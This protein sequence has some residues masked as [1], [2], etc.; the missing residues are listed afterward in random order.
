MYSRNLYGRSYGDERPFVIPSN[1]RGTALDTSV[2]GREPEQKDP[3]KKAR[4]D[5]RREEPG[6]A[7]APERAA[8]TVPEYGGEDRS[9]SHAAEHEGADSRAAQLQTAAAGA[10]SGAEALPEVGGWRLSFEEIVLVGLILLLAQ[11]EGHEDLIL[12]L[13]LLLLIA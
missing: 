7:A 1:Y 10:G 11:Q 2:M 5:I 12:A 8:G 6:G 13:A 3:E 9:D 4:A